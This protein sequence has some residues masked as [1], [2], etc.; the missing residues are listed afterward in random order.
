MP[1]INHG[2][3]TYREHGISSTCSLGLGFKIWILEEE[4]EGRSGFWNLLRSSGIRS[5]EFW[6]RDTFTSESRELIFPFQ[7]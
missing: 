2:P 4:V 1:K 7:R 5:R 3:Y 6:I